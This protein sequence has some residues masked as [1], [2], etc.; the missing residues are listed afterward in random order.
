LRALALPFAIRRPTGEMKQMT[1]PG[2]VS[3]AGIAAR[4][5]GH[6]A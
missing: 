5:V 2:R 1:K 4:A 6:R 3:R